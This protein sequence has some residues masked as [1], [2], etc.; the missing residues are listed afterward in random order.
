MNPPLL[1]NDIQPVNPNRSATT[2]IDL[3]N[4]FENIFQLLLQ[5]Q[6]LLQPQLH[7]RQ[8]QVEQL[9]HQSLQ[10]QPHRR[11]YLQEQ[12]PPRLQVQLLYAAE[13][14][15]LQQQPQQQLLW[16]S[17]IMT[18]DSPYLASLPQIRY[19]SIVTLTQTCTTYTPLA[20]C[21]PQKLFIWPA[22]PTILLIYLYPKYNLQSVKICKFCP[23][24][25][26]TKKYHDQIVTCH[27]LKS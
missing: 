17:K 23:L 14:K 22:K 25:M 27:S 11:L 2:P 20:K 18:K 13:S 1:E 15:L 6:I 19:L 12:P 26:Q 3:L 16:R 4:L 9:R 21:G 10:R 7:R 24:N 5:S 8:Q